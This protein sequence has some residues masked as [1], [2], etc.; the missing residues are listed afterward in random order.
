MYDAALTLGGLSPPPVIHGMLLGARR[1][2]YLS[3]DLTGGHA[4]NSQVSDTPTWSPATKIA[5][6]DLAPYLEARDRLAVR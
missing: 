4:L 5:A 6:K 2:L 1:P 3:A